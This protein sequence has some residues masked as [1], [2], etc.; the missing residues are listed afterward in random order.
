V[1]GALGKRVPN[2]WKCKS[3]GSQGKSASIQLDTNLEAVVVDDIPKT[4][5]AARQLK[6][7]RQER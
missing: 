1:K 5:E 7:E 2:L 4:A 6:R 3:R